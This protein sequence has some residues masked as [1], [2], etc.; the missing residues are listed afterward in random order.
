MHELED[1]LI[2]ADARLAELGELQDNPLRIRI[3]E[4]VEALKRARP[5]TEDQLSELGREAV[6][7]P[8]PDKA[9]WQPYPD[10]YKN[11][12]S[13]FEVTHEDIRIE[14]LYLGSQGILGNAITGKPRASVPPEALHTCPRRIEDGRGPGSPFAGSE[15]ADVWT[16]KRTCSYCGSMHPDDVIRGMIEHSVELEPTDKN[17]KVYVKSTGEG[18]EHGKFYFQHFS[19]EQRKEFIRLINAKSVAIAMPGYFYRLPFFMTP[20]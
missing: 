17:Y 4:Q 6:F 1:L 15:E 8:F 5:I 2:D 20:L 10:Q 11:M 19:L 9:D 3:G 18:G 14:T 16:T 13:R 7:G 12:L